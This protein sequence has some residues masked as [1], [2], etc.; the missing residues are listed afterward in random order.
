MDD[1]LKAYE[2]VTTK[3]IREVLE[4]YPIDRTSVLA[5]GP[6]AE[7]GMASAQLTMLKDANGGCAPA[8]TCVTPTPVPSR[9]AA[10]PRS[11]P[12]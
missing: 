7:L 10:A 4:Q 8:R 1:E 9:S 6:L 2:A 12:G 3:T 11:T 5:L